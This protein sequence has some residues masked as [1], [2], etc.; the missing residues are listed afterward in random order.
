MALCIYTNS[1]TLQIC[2]KNL[3]ALLKANGK[4]WYKYIRSYQ[5]AMLSGINKIVCLVQQS[6]DKTSG[7]VDSPM[8]HS[9]IKCYYCVCVH[10]YA[11]MHGVK[12]YHC[13][14]CS[15]NNTEHHVHNGILLGTMI[16]LCPCIHIKQF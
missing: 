12:Q 3:A 1:I 6:F 10:A 7:Y 8:L 2:L 13:K 4:I 9:C 16:L 14:A 5:L 11:R 15:N